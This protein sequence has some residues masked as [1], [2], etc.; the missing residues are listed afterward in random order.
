MEEAEE[1]G[2]YRTNGGRGLKFL[3]PSADHLP[4]S[5]EIVLSEDFG[6]DVGTLCLS[7]TPYDFNNILFRG[8]GT[9]EDFLEDFGDLS[10]NLE[11]SFGGGFNKDLNQCTRTS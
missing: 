5:L 7:I 2:L 11:N 1:L 6:I 8:F 9:F 3:L 10:D 4:Q